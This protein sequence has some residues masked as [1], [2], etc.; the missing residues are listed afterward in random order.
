M[1]CLQPTIKKLYKKYPFKYN[2]EDLYKIFGHNEKGLDDLGFIQKNYFRCRM[3][4]DYLRKSD[5]MSMYNSLEFRCLC[6]MKI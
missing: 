5:M 1:E 4:S 6:L 2:S 3:Q